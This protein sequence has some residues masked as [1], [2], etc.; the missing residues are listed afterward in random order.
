MPS[1]MDLSSG[2]MQ[3]DMVNVPDEVF[4]LHALGVITAHDSEVCREREVSLAT[5]V[6]KDVCLSSTYGSI[7]TA[8]LINFGRH[9]ANML[10]K[11]LVSKYSM[12]EETVADKVNAIAAALVAE[13]KGCA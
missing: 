10:H 11:A 1:V 12:A 6:Q 7:R 5:L 3:K 13:V 8:Y 4:A 2:N 9:S